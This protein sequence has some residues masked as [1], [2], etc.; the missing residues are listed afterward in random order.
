MAAAAAAGG[1]N[2]A[3]EEMGIRVLPEWL[4]A[5]L[6]HLPPP[7]PGPPQ[8]QEQWVL[9]QVREGGREGGWR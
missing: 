9:A 2:A 7:P 4:V 6:A 1:I 5:C 8:Q 3:L